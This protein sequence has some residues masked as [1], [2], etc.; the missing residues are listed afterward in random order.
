MELCRRRG[1]TKDT[2]QRVGITIGESY[3]GEAAELDIRTE[4]AAWRSGLQLP[5]QLAAQLAAA[6]LAAPVAARLAP[7]EF[8]LP[9][10]SG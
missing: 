1:G 7:E 9:R 4:L 8:R 5:V 10:K 3:T 6:Q 2:R